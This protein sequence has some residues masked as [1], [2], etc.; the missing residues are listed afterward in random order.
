MP[1]YDF[2]RNLEKYA[3]VLVKIGLNVQP[4]QRVLISGAPPGAVQ[5]VRAVAAQAYQAGARYV[6]VF[7]NDEQLDLIRFQ[8]APRDSFEEY[9]TW[10]TEVAV[11]SAARGDA[12]LSLSA[13]TPDLLRGQDPELVA[14]A[15]RVSAQY[16]KPVI[17]IAIK[18][19]TNWLVACA[20][21]AGWSAKVL[22]NVPPEQREQQMWDVLFKI[23]RIDQEDPVAGWRTHIRALLERSAY[24]NHKHYT[25][26]R[27]KG[28][29]TNLTIG[30][31]E[32]HLWSGAE[33]M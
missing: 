30:L 32:G 8:H 7:W 14:I 24:L 6:D 21:V 31:P 2:Q 17:D 20:P 19:V 12:F 11:A 16:R 4:G 33:E 28:P 10:R 29:G 1:P 3:Q 22:P 27:Y 13:L 25:A 15:Q 26:L 9:P 18:N 23:C 5:M